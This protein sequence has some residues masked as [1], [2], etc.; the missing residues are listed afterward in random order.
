MLLSVA[1]LFD[2]PGVFL[3]RKDDADMLSENI[4]RLRKARGLSQEELAERLKVVRQTVSK[5]EQGLSVPDAD[6]LIR[7]AQVLDTRVSILLGEDVETAGDPELVKALSEKLEELNRAYAESKE[8]KRKIWH[9]VFWVLGILCAPVVAE[10]IYVYGAMFAAMLR[11]N[12]TAVA[13]IGGADGPTTMWVSAKLT[14]LLM[15]ARLIVPPVI[16]LIIA[17]IGI[18]K[19]RKHK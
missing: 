18:R 12:Q 14:G 6:M 19:T 3:R 4:K 16:G 10:L 2:S 13:V 9:V 1:F 5:W 17:V 15:H 7:I 8:T 11:S